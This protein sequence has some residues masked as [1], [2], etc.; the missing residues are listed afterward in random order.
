[1]LNKDLLAPEVQAY[2]G[3][4]VQ[5]D[6][7]QFS[8]KKSPFEGITSGELAQQLWGRVKSKEKLPLWH[9]AQGIYFPAKL[10]LEQA[11]SEATARYKAS[12]VGGGTLLDAT[13]GFGVDD[14]YFAQR[15]QEVT[16][17][18]LQEELSEIV[19]H[20]FE[21]LGA[22]V[23]CIAEDSYAYLG[24]EGKRY[25]TI[26]LDP[27][28][29]DSHKQKVFFLEDCTPNV[30]ESLD[31]LWQY[32]DALLVKASPMLD[33]SRALKQLPQT[34]QV[35]I[36]AVA[37]E[38]KELLFLL[39]KTPLEGEVLLKT[40]HM[41]P[42]RT[43]IFSFFPSE[44][45]PKDI[46]MTRGY[47]CRYLY[48]PNAALLKGNGLFPVG[49]AYGLKYLNRDSQLLLGA[50]YIPD[51]PGRVFLIDELLAYD[52]KLLKSG[53]IAQAN[54]TVRNFPM[55]VSEIRERFSIAEG[56]NRYLFFTQGG[57]GNK[58]VI[59]CRKPFV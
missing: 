45:D 44:T 40:V 5:E 10:S 28:R 22:N 13:G 14:Y 58:L 53:K 43:D 33:I 12:L 55:K 16:H 36:V 41:L 21:V 47:L 17:C 56:G 51:F 19:A 46:P 37:G 50:E 11:S 15:C 9:Q 4:H 31:F 20:N 57:I 52:R 1:M 38:V 25:D 30:P 39:K 23:R 2:I 35:H 48:E 24:R 27:A 42:T 6:I 26:Y 7:A 49:R 54:I 59:I 18:E 32:T 8:L 3:A 34:H 29:R